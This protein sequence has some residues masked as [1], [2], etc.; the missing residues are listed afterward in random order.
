[1]TAR[2]DWTQPEIEALFALPFM[3]LVRRAANVH[4]ENHDPSRIQLCTL[5]NIKRGGC[6]EDCSYCP[7]SAHHSAMAPES[8]LS[9][10]EVVRQATAARDKG[11]SRFCMGAAWRRVTDGTDFDQVVD[12]VREVNDL[13]MEVC[14][15][16]GMLN[17]D[18]AQR[19]REA[20]LTAYNHNIDT[21][22]EYYERII[23]TRNFADRIDTI[24]KVRDAGIRVCSGGIVGMGETGADRAGMLRV[25][26]NMAPHPESVPINKLVRAP[27][28]PLAGLEEL[29][30]LDFIRTIAV[31]RILMPGSMV[32]LAAGRL[33]LSKEARILAHMAGANSI[34]YGEELLTTSNPAIDED[35]RVLET[36][37]LQPLAPR[38][39]ARQKITLPSAAPQRA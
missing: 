13:G 9:V 23:S 39:L 38:P 28:T 2:H 19:L 20:G 24:G 34:F 37:G 36:L 35:R 7:Q 30:T 10:E 17:A 4:A 32:R 16:L 33:S 8:L 6:P 29:D 14:V 11:A 25:L 5:A 18:Q 15:T 31:A 26:S 22:P 21:S 12:M 27:N 1:M 3:E